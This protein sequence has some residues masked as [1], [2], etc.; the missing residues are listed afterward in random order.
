M[1]GIANE[2]AKDLGA[3]D[4]SLIDRLDSYIRGNRQLYWKIVQPDAESMA[5]QSARAGL[6][7]RTV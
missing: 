2:A 7:R 3:P 5:A 4:Q 1:F 6:A